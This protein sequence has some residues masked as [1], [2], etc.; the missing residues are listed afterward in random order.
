MMISV[1][2]SV[3]LFVLGGLFLLV[4]P[5]ILSREGQ[6]VFAGTG[7]VSVVVGLY[8]RGRERINR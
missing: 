2:L 1:R 6:A 7:A 5:L 8:A 4:A 3:V